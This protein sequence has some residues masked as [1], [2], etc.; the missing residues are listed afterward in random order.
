[1]YANTRVVQTAYTPTSLGCA[2]CLCP[3]VTRQLPARAVA[4]APSPR[5]QSVPAGLARDLAS[6]GS[7]WGLLAGDTSGELG[8][9]LE[10][11]GAGGVR[12]RPLAGRGPPGARGSGAPR[13]PPRAPGRGLRAEAARARRCGGAAPASGREAAPP[14]P[15]RSCCRSATFGQTLPPRPRSPAGGW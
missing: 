10:P 11:P 14:L 13:T 1:M 7:R 3:T 2:G 4:G 9:P 8:E 6:G 15:L 5:G 12:E